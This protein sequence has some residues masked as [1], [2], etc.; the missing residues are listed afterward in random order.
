MEREKEVGEVLSELEKQG[1]KGVDV[2]D[3]EMVKAHGRYMVGG[4]ADV[5]H[6]RVFRFG[7]KNIVHL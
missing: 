1:M 4:C 3:N 2:S 6:E 5:P 7:E